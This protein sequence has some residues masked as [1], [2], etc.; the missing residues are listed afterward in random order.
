MTAV[1]QLQ[2]AMFKVAQ[3]KAVS[4]ENPKALAKGVPAAGQAQDSKA[5]IVTNPKKAPTQGSSK[6]SD[7][8]LKHLLAPSAGRD[9]TIKTPTGVAGAR[10]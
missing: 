3:E 9:Y 5:P 1:E 8:D 2:I 7:N 10:G 6:L 4:L